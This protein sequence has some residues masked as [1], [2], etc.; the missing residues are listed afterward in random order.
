MKE[1][2][3]LVKFWIKKA[4]NDLITAENLLN[5]LPEPPLDIICFHAQQCAEKYLKA[6]LI[7]HGIEFE[8]LII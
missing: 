1:K 3:D 7:Y 2:I 8:K 6:F 4:E 5:I